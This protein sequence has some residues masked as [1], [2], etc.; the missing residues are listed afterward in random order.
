MTDKPV[1]ITGPNG[2]QGTCQ[3][4]ALPTWEAN[5]WTAA[6]E[7]EAAPRDDRPETLDAD[8]PAATTE[9]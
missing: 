8:G 4:S 9:E 6:A 5:G 2:E 7:P 3:P 1:A